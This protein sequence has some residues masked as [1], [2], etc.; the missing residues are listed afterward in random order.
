MARSTFGATAADYVISLG[1]GGILRAAPATL[2]FWTAPTGGT[3]HTDLL[4]NA[5]PTST[6]TVGNDGMVPAFQGPDGV[7]QMWADA[8][9][10][11]RIRIVAGGEPG[12]EG[13]AGV[14]DDSSVAA[15]V[16]DTGSDTR[17]QIEL[18]VGGPP[19]ESP[20]YEPEDYGAEGDGTTDDGDA[21]RA[22]LAAAKA[23]GGGVVRG[24]RD[25]AF[26]GD[27]V[28]GDGVW[29]EGLG[30]NENPGDTAAFGLHA[31]DATS[32]VRVGDWTTDQRPGGLS[33]I[34]I[35]G[36]G[37]GHPDGLVC[38][39][40]VGAQFDAV[41]IQR[42]D[43]H[44]LVFDAAQNSTVRGLFS[45]LAGDAALALI[46][47][48][49]GL[50]FVGC[51]AVFSPRSLAIYDTNGV[52]DNAYPYGSAHINFFGGILETSSAVPISTVADIRAG[53]NLHFWGTGF[54][55]NTTTTSSD[56]CVVKVSNPDFPG[57]ATT[58]GFHS[59]NFNGGTNQYP[60]IR[61]AG[62]SNRVV[63]TGDTYWQQ[64]STFLLSDG[65][66]PIVSMLGTFLPGPSAGVLLG[67]VN[68]GNL[69]NVF[70]PK[71]L[72]DDYRLAAATP[73][74][75]AVRRDSDGNTGLRYFLNRDGVHSWTDGTGFV[76][77]QALSYST[78]S[79]VLAMSSLM[80]TGRRMSAFTQHAVSTAGE[81]VTI[82][83]RIN[84]HE[85]YLSAAGTVTTMTITNPVQGAEIELW[86]TQDGTGGHS[87]VWPADIDWG[88]GGAAPT[89]T[90]AS[91]SVIVKLQYR[92]GLAKWFVKSINI[93]AAGGGGSVAWDDVTDKPATF[94]PSAHDHAAAD[95]TS[96]TFDP[97]RLPAASE[98]AQ[99]AV[100]LA[101]SAETTTGTDTT[102][103]THPAGVKAAI[104]AAVAALLDSA[105]GALDTLN[106]LAAALGDDPNF[107]STMTT[108]L[109]GKQPLDDELTALAAVTS[110]ANKLP[111]FTGLGAA[112]VTD[113]TAFART[114][115]DDA[116]AATMRATLGITASL[117]AFEVTTATAV[118]AAAKTATI[119]GG[120]AYTDG[121]LISVIATN[122]NTA[123]AP[124]LNIDGLGAKSI[125]L[126]G[127][128]VT[129]YSGVLA[130]NGRW[131]LRYDAATDRFDLEG[132]T[133]NY[134]LI[135]QATM[136][137]GTSTTVGWMTPQRVAQ[138]IAALAHVAAPNTQTG[139]Y[140]LVLADQGKRIRY[141]A[142][143][144]ANITIPPN[145]SV[146]FPVGTHIEV[147]QV[148][149][150][151]ATVVPGSG[152]TINNASSAAT[153][154]Q[155][156]VLVLYKDAT[157]SWTVS[158]DMQ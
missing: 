104:D 53:A 70:N 157:D 41:F 71:V 56:A 144:A 132:V 8:G 148:G 5:A 3:Q 7:T 40:G 82:D 50:N 113:L 25:Y 141:N 154:A 28:I 22:A 13:P 153:R 9:G 66:A 49:G 54:S 112:A 105:P 99:G 12:P 118:G 51:H 32:R 35:D 55:I 130:A 78:S 27:L 85:V 6:I 77:K 74:A 17:A 48:S 18:L 61:M 128:A 156:S 46:N 83:S 88:P 92:T 80:V 65:A 84:T 59:C 2:K 72:F 16:A 42:A 89:D 86:I 145:S 69:V 47:G 110:A 138:A 96:G 4:L 68:S 24:A 97:A 45:T 31:L 114:L 39:Q 131:F 107:A 109:A 94:A 73:T 122:G 23:A 37:T 149:A 44:N 14:A 124:T 63:V 102:R 121:D 116:D 11:E 100:E 67:T 152:V 21:L 1:P 135:A 125:F 120:Y 134:D 57:I 30:S 62:G 139:A 129:L 15:L 36:H 123:A 146:A 126:G 108:A 95:V 136:E 29:L 81:T 155:H 119:G 64:S 52:T 137:A 93:V 87:Y 10:G 43:G 133:A 142:A 76:A 158:G 20:E 151:Q 143:G 33:R 103:A 34:R 58:V 75:L 38:V 26:T 127:S 111:Y 60:T 101:S 98:A 140:T 106:E 147:A 90:T 79:D 115:L 117:R 19:W 150:G 91:K